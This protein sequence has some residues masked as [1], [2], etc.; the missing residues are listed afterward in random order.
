MPGT[1]IAC[2]S[3]VCYTALHAPSRIEGRFALH[4]VPCGIFCPHVYNLIGPGTVVN[5]DTLGQELGKLQQAGVDTH[6]IHI[7]LRAHPAVGPW[8]SAVVHG[9]RVAMPRIQ[10]QTRS[11]VWHGR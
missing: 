7:D 2:S 10:L 8:A 5:L 3:C 9:R 1:I 4:L 11:E 6:N